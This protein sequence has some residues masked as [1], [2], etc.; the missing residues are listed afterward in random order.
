M[1]DQ[2]ALDTDPAPA[3]DKAPKA[4]TPSKTT[5]K[6]AAP[7]KTPPAKTSTAKTAPKTT[8]KKS[9][10]RGGRPSK[11]DFRNLCAGTIDQLVG[12]L[13]L[14]GLTNERIAYDAEVIQAQADALTDE[15]F[16][17]GWDAATGRTNRFGQWLER[18]NTIGEWGRTASLIVGIGI[19]LAANHGLVPVDTVHLVNLTRGADPLKIPEPVERKPKAD[20]VETIPVRDDTAAGEADAE[21][22]DRL[23]WPAV[24]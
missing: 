24:S 4:P 6:K 3:G 18:A 5:A 12:L 8:R 23:G 14:G 1:T 19:P 15:L 13:I 9:T 22:L 20:K 21:T 16:A 7:P 2:Q 10:P 11:A 17:R